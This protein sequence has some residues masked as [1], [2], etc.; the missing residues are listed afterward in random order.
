MKRRL[1]RTS[2]VAALS[3][4]VLLGLVGSAFAYSN[5]FD[6]DT[7]GWFDN[8]GTITQRP[9]GYDNDAYADAIASSSD[10]FH[11]RLDRGA[12]ETQSGGSGDAVNC[13]GPFT[14]WDGYSHLWN[15]PF[16]TQVDV[17]LDTAYAIANPDTYAG[18][19]ADLTAPSGSTNPNVK[20]TRFDYTTAINKSTLDGGGNTQHLRDFGFNVSTGYVDD[21]C[22]GFMV[23]GQTNVNRINANPNIGGHDPRC[24][25]ETGWYTF[26]HSFSDVDGFLKV[27]MEIIPV[28]SSTPAAS[29]T[30]TGIDPHGTFGCNRYSWFSNQEIFGLPI[31]N[32]SLTGGCDLTPPPPTGTWTQSGSSTKT[33]EAAVQQPIN[34]ANTSNWSSKS[35]GGIPVMFK[36]K[37]ATGPEIFQSVY[38]DQSDQNDSSYMSFTPSGPMKFADLRNLTASYQFVAGDCAWGALRWEL[39]L[40]VD[41]DGSHDGN[42]WL[43]YGDT[44][45]GWTKCTGVFSNSGVNM[46][47]LTDARWDNSQL[48]SFGGTYGQTLAQTRALFN[49]ATVLSATLPLDGGEGTAGLDQILA[50]GTTGT[51]NGNTYTWQSG[52][53]SSFTDTCDL[54]AA[55][56]QVAKSD[57]V[58]DGAINEDP[59][60]G[61]LSDAGNA[62][63]VVDC[64]YQYILSIP[65][66]DG[67][68]TYRVLI[69]IDGVS[70]PTPTSPDGK[71][72][73]DIK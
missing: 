29:W 19:L 2:I 35:K 62:F 28:G 8:G 10:G 68:G 15:G 21:G 54:P 37:E 56:I 64:K 7:A 36:L 4:G 53:G 42:A 69:K 16:T 63:R 14:R 11:A 61:S 66:L 41:N 60:Q 43:Y 27:V 51:V 44:A 17:Y 38:S 40:D 39:S 5:D 20:G 34:T 49:N 71:V 59:V 31:D 9:S 57:N 22:D 52:S 25:D 55:T 33:Y 48:G 30:I 3:A 1:F 72:K 58:A 18:N 12:C 26:K 50:A 23:T 65:S 6:S 32:A 13:S 45:S 47:T 70:V 67:K 46:M 24:I 73:F